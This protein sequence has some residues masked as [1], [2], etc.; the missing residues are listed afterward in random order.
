MTMVK[1][2]FFFY[3]FPIIF[4]NFGSKT[5]INSSKVISSEV[6]VRKCSSKTVFL[7]T[8]LISQENI[9]VVV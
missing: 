9:C 8:S 3:G 6:V 5:Y 2:S 7:K 1:S 4:Y